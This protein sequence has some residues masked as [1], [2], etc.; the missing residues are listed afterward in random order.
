LLLFLF[1]VSDGLKNY[2]VYGDSHERMDINPIHNLLSLVFHV[3]SGT[4]HPLASH[5]VWA[6]C[7]Y[8]PL[9]DVCVDHR[10]AE[11]RGARNEINAVIVY[12][13]LWYNASSSSSRRLAAA[14]R[15]IQ[16]IKGQKCIGRAVMKLM[17]VMTTASTAKC[18]VMSIRI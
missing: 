6:A 9:V 15:H 1:Y 2:H 17:I 12:S 7:R 11:Q 16:R 13:F 8:L 3:L 5:R 4:L 10:S 14:G 18:I